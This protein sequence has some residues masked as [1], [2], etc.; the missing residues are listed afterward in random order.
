MNIILVHGAWADGSSWSRVIPKLLNAGHNVTAAQLPLT[1]LSNDIKRVQELLDDFT[2]PTLLVGH[3]YGCAVVTGAGTDAKQVVGVVY[4][5]GFALDEGE[6]LAD[7]FSK[8]PPLPSGKYIKPDAHGYLW[9]E[10]K[11]FPK[12]FAADVDLKTAKT[13]AVV[14]N[15]IAGLGFSEKSG[16]P[17]WKKLPSWYQVS[18]DDMMIPPAAERMMAKRAN[19]TTISLNSSHASLVSHWKQV[20][21]FILLATKGKKE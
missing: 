12:Y 2:G 21:N 17:A 1:S 10:P 11:Y 4:I 13:M 3:S 19:A 15:P 18:N 20:A 9:V 5:A 7:I 14:Q 16:P 8:Y 6:S